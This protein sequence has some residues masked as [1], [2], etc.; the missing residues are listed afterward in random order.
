[1]CLRVYDRILNCDKFLLNVKY[2]FVG[3]FF[4]KNSPKS[5]FKKP[6]NFSQ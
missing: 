3:D 2:L 6:T 5:G 4:D 1:M